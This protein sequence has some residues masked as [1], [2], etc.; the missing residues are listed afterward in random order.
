MGLG[1]S[2]CNRMML[3]CKLLVKSS[4]KVLFTAR[5]SGHSPACLTDT[6]GSNVPPKGLAWIVQLL[7]TCSGK[8]WRMK[9]CLQK[10]HIPNGLL[11]CSAS[12]KRASRCAHRE[13][14]L[15]EMHEDPVNDCPGEHSHL[16]V[17]P[18]HKHISKT[19]RNSAISPQSQNKSNTHHIL[20]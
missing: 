14:Y 16:L 17:F 2:V 7:S 9:R 3:W 8:T 11:I 19:L 5:L 1:I 12:D 10:Q 4:T 6:L 15:P 20:C 18:H 13:T